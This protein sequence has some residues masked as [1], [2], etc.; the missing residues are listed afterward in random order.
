VFSDRRPR[1]PPRPRKD[2]EIQD[3]NEDDDE[4]EGHASPNLGKG[5]NLFWGYRSTLRL[6][7]LTPQLW[8][9]GERVADRRNHQ[10]NQHSII[11]K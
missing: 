1:S 4:E 6:S 10:P 5:F 8:Y 9:S 3:E 7:T 11:I 2:Y